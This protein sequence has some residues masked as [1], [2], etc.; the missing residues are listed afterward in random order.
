[1]AWPADG[2]SASSEPIRGR[3]RGEPS[4]AG[5]DFSFA[6]SD[7]KTLGAFFCNFETLSF[8]RSS[9]V[10]VTAP[11]YQILWVRGF[12]A[13]T[14][15]GRGFNLFKALRRHF[16]ATPLCRQT[17]SRRA[18]FC[19]IESIPS[20]ERAAAGAR[21]REQSEATQTRGLQLRL[22]LDTCSPCS[23]LQPLVPHARV[24]DLARPWMHKGEGAWGSRTR[25]FLPCVLTSGSLSTVSDNPQ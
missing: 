5:A 2:C 9:A 10:A 7:F 17:L 24:S 6:S 19:A 23:K 22:G 11:A 20:K 14:I 4:G 13:H 12:R 1:V 18:T 8:L 25:G 3:G 16:R 15:S 21:H